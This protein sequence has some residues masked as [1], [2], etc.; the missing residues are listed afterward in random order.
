MEGGGGRGGSAVLPPYFAK[1]HT[2]AQLGQNSGAVLTALG[3]GPFFSPQSQ[4]SGKKN[5]A[6]TK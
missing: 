2:C 5:C 6:P 3:M 1:P 4:S